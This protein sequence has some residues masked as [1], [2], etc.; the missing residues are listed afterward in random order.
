MQIDVQLIKNYLKNRGLTRTHFCKE[1][2]I[3]IVD[4]NK[5]LTESTNIKLV[6]L[7]KIAQLMGVP[8]LK[9]FIDKNNII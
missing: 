4:F 6:V 3:S 9:L 7:F 8:V 5:I 1:C 2:K